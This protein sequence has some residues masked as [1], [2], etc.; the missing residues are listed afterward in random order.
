MFSPR[1]FTRWTTCERLP[2][3]SKASSFSAATMP[4]DD[5]ILAL[6]NGQP[7]QLTPG[8]TP[9]EETDLMP[10]YRDIMDYP[11]P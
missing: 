4:D 9:T 5:S 3:V 6:F 10:L 11:E 7:A 1:A 8:V 2:Q